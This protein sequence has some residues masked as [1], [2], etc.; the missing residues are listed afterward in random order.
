MRTYAR[1]HEREG[2][3][4]TN[5]PGGPGAGIEPAPREGGVEGGGWILK[6]EGGGGSGTPGR[7]CRRYH[8]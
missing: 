8:E 2:S 3:R 4:F 1:A 6:A 7:R 5:P